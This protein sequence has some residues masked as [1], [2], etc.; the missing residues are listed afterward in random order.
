MAYRRFLDDPLVRE[1]VEVVGGGRVDGRRWCVYGPLRGV[2]ALCLACGLTP[3]E[4]V[5]RLRSGGD[6]ADVWKRFFTFL[7]GRG[8]TGV[9]VRRLL[10][11]IRG[12]LSYY[13]VLRSV[14]WDYVNEL[15]RR[16]FGRGLTRN[17]YARQEG[18]LTRDL[19]RRILIESCRTTRDRVFVLV[20]AT[21]GVSFGDALKLRVGDFEDLHPEQD[22]YMLQYVRSK[23]GQKATTF[24]T[25]ECRDWILKYLDERRRAG[26]AITHESPLLAGKAGD[27]RPL[28]RTRAI[29]IIRRI[30]DS[31]G[32]TETIGVDARGK[33]RY[34]YHGHL[35]RKYFRT[36]L[37][38]AGV[39]RIYVEAMMGHDI[40][41]MFGVEMVYDKQA[42]KPEVLREQ[43]LKALHEL[44]FLE[45]VQGRG[46][47]VTV[48][49][50]ARLV[51]RIKELEAKI[52][53]LD[54][55][56]GRRRW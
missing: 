6:C 53:L 33:R 28:R 42:D 48:D 39:D 37:R 2:S 21:S 50:L 11:G 5:E 24:I 55:M 49:D 22:C 18:E 45:P 25:R 29:Q 47:E 44:T 32:L 56:D 9:T 8:C 26:E 17:V 10:T 40:H 52:K 23:T 30:F 13:N 16:V 15:K 51:E 35:F 34:K 12:F 31:A 27:G 14:D 41:S 4:L 36:A 38:N 7:R 43:Y 20:M 19:I 46:Q 54:M 3:S 1:F